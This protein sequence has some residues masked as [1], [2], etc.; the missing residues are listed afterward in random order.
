[1]SASAETVTHYTASGPR[2]GMDHILAEIYI[3]KAISTA[4]RYIRM[5]LKAISRHL[6]KNHC[7]ILA[8]FHYYT[9]IRYLFMD[10]SHQLPAKVKRGQTGHS[11]DDRKDIVCQVK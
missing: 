7:P 2:S 1:M 5:A 10:Y 3:A 8:Q 9:A 6:Q 11:V 4:Y